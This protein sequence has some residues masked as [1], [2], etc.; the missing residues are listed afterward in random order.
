MRVLV[1]FAHPAQRKSSINVAMAS[2]A[3]N[4]DGITFV[5][6]YAEYPRFSIDVD[7]EQRRL[8][9]HDVIVFQFPVFWY[10]TPALL[11]QWQD[12]V[13]EY[14][15]AYGPEGKRL[16]GKLVMPCITT[17]GSRAD[18]STKGGNRR[19]IEHFLYPL[20]QTAVLCGM[21]SLPPFVLHSANHL[22]EVSAQHHIA[23]FPQLLAALRD[24]RFDFV[25]ARQLQT[26]N[27]FDLNDLI[28]I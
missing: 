20:E 12:L 2:G 6:L 7:R 28:R 21:E 1:L 19:Q 3:R 27:S 13:L 9:E 15:F 5:D 22:A 14:G 23:A 4:L 16:A 11:K 26:F 17:G 24:E 8:M 25:S 18:Y 10:S